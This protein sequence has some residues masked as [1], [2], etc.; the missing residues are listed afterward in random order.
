MIINIYFIVAFYV[1]LEK[2]DPIK[3]KNEYE[4]PQ[5]TFQ[6]QQLSIAQFFNETLFSFF[7]HQ[8][9]SAITLMMITHDKCVRSTHMLQVE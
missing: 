7:D 8:L 6:Q 9:L 3:I 4:H 1:L 2:T 5:E